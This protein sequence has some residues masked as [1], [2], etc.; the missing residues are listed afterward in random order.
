MASGL[1]RSGQERAGPVRRRYGVSRAPA[2]R[3]AGVASSPAACMLVTVRSTRRAISPK[4]IRPPRKAATATSL[5]AFSAVGAPPPA[6]QR[7]DGDAERGETLEVRALE[8]QTAER[9]EVRPPNA[10]G[11]ALRI[12]EAMGDRRAHVG[13]GHAGDQRTVDE[14]DQPVDDR[15]GMDD[16]VEPLGRAPNRK[17]A[18]ISSR[19]LFIRRRRIDRDLGA[20]SP[21]SGGRAPRPG[22]RPRCARRSIRGKGRRRR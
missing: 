4:P 18:S 21:N 13:R 12:G 20:P 7:I 17:W 14:G 1:R 15:L 19:P 2:Q 11:D 10:R 3:C 8:G 6:L 9:S 22:W 5:A 16:H